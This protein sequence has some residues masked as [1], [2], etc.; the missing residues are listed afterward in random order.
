MI[1]SVWKQ[2]AASVRT[3]FLY[4]L[5]TGLSMADEPFLESVLDDKSNDVRSG[6]AD[7]L[8]DL[9]ESRFTQRMI[10]ATTPLIALKRL[11][12]GTLFGIG[13]SNK[14][15]IEVTLSQDYTPA[16]KRD[17][18]EQKPTNTQM[19]ERAYWLLQQL[20]R[21]PPGIWSDQWQAEPH[22][23]VVAIANTKDWKAI[24]NEALLNATVRHADPSWAEAFLARELATLSQYSPS[25][26]VRLLDPPRRDEIVSSALSRKPEALYTDEMP[27]DILWTLRKPWTPDVCRA[28]L[29]SV[30]HHIK[31]A[32][33]HGNWQ[34]SQTIS[35]FAYSMTPSILHEAESILT[36]TDDT[37]NNLKEAVDEF[38]TTLQFRRDMLQ[39]LN[40]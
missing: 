11:R 17:G 31:K 19:G 27:V 13:A 26:L 40:E 28:V 21:I 6:A 10:E 35:T 23:I 15:Y 34:V 9:P 14:D 38:L 1:E 20:S 39:A 32:P 7:L 18:I 2:E 24:L 25:R 37:S 29:R 8:A 5:R 33:K 12:Q 16:M 4:A 22:E 3:Q 36:T 30:A